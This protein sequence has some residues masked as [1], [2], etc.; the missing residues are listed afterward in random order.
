[1][2]NDDSSSDNSAVMGCEPQHSIDSIILYD[3]LHNAQDDNSHE[4]VPITRPSS[5]DSI[6]EPAAAMMTVEGNDAMTKVITLINDRANLSMEQMQVFHS[7]ISGFVDTLIAL[8]GILKESNI[9]KIIR[10]LGMFTNTV[11]IETILS[12]HACLDA[13]NI[14]H[15]QGNCQLAA[16]APEK[17][18]SEAQLRSECFGT[19]CNKCPRL[20]VRQWCHRRR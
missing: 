8:K 2:D 12:N 7:D 20:Y 14:V 17:S 6:A 11:F 3:W 9:A 5:D 15:K 1:M 13:R 4:I 10:Q 18:Q 16:A 19:F